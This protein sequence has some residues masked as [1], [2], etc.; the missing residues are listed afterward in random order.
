MSTEQFNQNP[1][2]RDQ[3]MELMEQRHQNA[4]TALELERMLAEEQPPTDYPAIINPENKAMLQKASIRLQPIIE[5]LKKAGLIAQQEAIAKLA[6]KYIVEKITAQRVEIDLKE[7]ILARGGQATPQEV[8]ALLFKMR[9]G[10]QPAKEVEAIR[11]EGYFIVAFSNDDDYFKFI[12]DLERE[13]SGGQFHRTMRFPNMSVDIIVSRQGLDTRIIT[14]ERQHFINN[15]I[16]NNFEGF[17]EQVPA[18]KDYP[19]LSAVYRKRHA[20]D[21]DAYELAKYDSTRMF[22]NKV[23][24]ELLARV[25][26]GGDEAWSTNFFTHDLYAYLRGGFHED[27]EKEVVKLLEEIKPELEAAYVYFNYPAD[28]R[29]ILVYHLLDIPL[30]RFPER[31]RAVVDYYK[32]RINEFMQ[33]IPSSANSQDLLPNQ[34][35]QDIENLRMEIQGESYVA[36]E[37]ILGIQKSDNPKK[38]L[39]A[40]KTRII[41]L[42]VKYDTLVSEFAYSS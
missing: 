11:R 33:Y 22:L 30:I 14:H 1:E 37:L 6:K 15:S 3:K 38:E 23:K 16:F 5:K 2:R 31:I 7:Q 35:S 36:A 32:T 13:A 18:K 20:S 8:G 26:D 34:R 21:V 40:I 17:Q 28:A 41:S 42:R 4:V 27:E 24:D 10:T 19:L 29:G 12:G 9:T 39:D 25:R